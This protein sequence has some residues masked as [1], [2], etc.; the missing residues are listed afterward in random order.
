MIHGLNGAEGL[1]GT[2]YSLMPES[3]YSIE[4]MAATI[5]KGQTKVTIP[6]TVFPDQFDFSKDF[7]IPLRIVSASEGTLSAHFSVAILAVGV[8]NIYDGIYEIAGGTITRNSAT[9]PDPVL[10]GTYVSGL[11]LE[12]VTLAS[13]RVSFAPRWKDGSAVGGIDGTS[14][15]INEAT[16][17]TTVVS[18]AN[19]TL[20]HIVGSENKYD[21]ATKEFTVNI[22]WGNP[23]NTRIIQNL[24]LKYVSSRP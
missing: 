14:I 22:Q 21:P 16:N 3:N 19:A 12:L 7:A 9:V 20:K 11:E 4:S 15:T 5:P 6:I 23:P 13:N 1:H 8:R 2:T 24:K 18:S 10:G 17:Q